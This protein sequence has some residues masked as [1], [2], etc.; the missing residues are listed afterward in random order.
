[1]NAFHVYAE[2]AGS[3][4]SGGY[5]S[6]KVDKVVNLA[7][8]NGLYVILTIGSGGDNGSF[9]ANFVSQFWN[10]YAPRYKDKT[11]VVYEIM[12]EPQAWSAPYN[13]TTLSMEKNTFDLIR[14]QAPNTHIMLMSYSVPANASQAADECANLGISW[15]NASV[16]FHG[17]GI[18][19]N[20][21]SYLSS[22]F[23]AFKNKGIAVTCTEP[24]L[25]DGKANATTTRIFENNGVSYTHFIKAHNV[26]ATNSVY[27][28]VINNAG[29]VWT[30]DYGV[31]PSPAN[32]TYK[33]V[34]RN[35]G[36]AMDA[37]GSAN[38]SQIQQY[39]YSAGNN[40]KWTLTDIGGGVRKII[41]V[42]SG[43]A[44]DVA[45]SGTANG[46][47]VQLYDYWAGSGQVFKFA[48]T[49]DGYFRITPQCATSRC[50]DMTG[51]STANNAKVQLYDYWGGNAQQW[52]TKTP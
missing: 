19:G 26:A 6:S 42:A 46:T 25:A 16:A 41:G 18:N 28:D 43:R 50:L 11:H 33:L 30:P 9:N 5:N 32:G 1:L 8:T 2:Y 34:N 12:N 4:Q 35:S 14:N 10:Y 31:W 49:G 17:Y 40:Q 23:T 38:G 15:A 51:Q 20:E 27:Y 45:S 37:A 44:V 22:W 21:S 47:K 7:E 24:E 13:S 52:G 29:I 36:K 3:G 39:T 48:G